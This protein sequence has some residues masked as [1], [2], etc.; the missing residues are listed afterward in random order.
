MRKL[1]FLQILL[2]DVYLD[3]IHKQMFLHFCLVYGYK[4]FSNIHCFL[5]LTFALPIHNQKHIYIC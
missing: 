2:Y 5:C 4:R 1:L 3:Y